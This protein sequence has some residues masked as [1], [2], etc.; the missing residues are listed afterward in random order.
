MTTFLARCQ[1]PALLLICAMIA[2]ARLSAQ[3]DLDGLMMA[4]NNYCS[5]FMYGYSSWEDYWE[6][7]FK[8]DNKNLGT[9][10]TQMI[11]YMGNYGINN[12]LNAIISLPYVITKASA[13]TMHGMNGIQDLSL[14]LKY[15]ALQSKIGKGDLKLFG[16]AGFSFPLGNYSADFLPLSIGLE[17]RTLSLRVMGDYQVGHFFVTAS[18]TYMLRDNIK[19]DRDNYFTT[20]MHYTNEVK[21]PDAFTSNLRVGYRS[22]RFIAEAVLMDMKTLGGFDITKNN[23]PFPSNEM[24]ATAAGVSFKHEFNNPLSGFSLTAGASQ[25]IAGRNVGQATS[26]NIGAFYVLDFNKKNRP[27]QTKK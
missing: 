3:T 26:F 4:K 22:N 27:V 21:M 11:G 15:K 17:S 6:G 18:G 23:M 7:T 2:M 13:G 20:E 5:G 19:I 16:V 8:R 25:V 14:F 12:K 24:N 1:R 10:S 9:V